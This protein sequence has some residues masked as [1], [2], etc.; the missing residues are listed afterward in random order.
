[1][2]DAPAI[3]SGDSDHVASGNGPAL[4]TD[5]ARQA[6]VSVATVSRALSR[7]EM[8]SAATRDLVQTAVRGTGYRVNQAARN[9]RKQR[10][11][12][13]VA[14]VP[15]LGSPFFAKILAGMGAE[16]A[17]AGYDLLVADTMQDGGRHRALARF[18]DASRADGIIL[19][20]GQVTADDLAALLRAPPVVMACGWINDAA[21][22]RVVLNNGLGI[23]LAARHLLDLDHRRIGWIGGP[24]ENVLHLARCEGLERVLGHLPPG[25]P[26]DFSV[27]SGAGRT[28]LAGRAG[29][30]PPERHRVLQRRNGCGFCR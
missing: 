30:H 21:L 4:L 18:L 14:L 15:N 11:G 10:A 9:L 1:M 6:G 29:M 27:A 2:D 16:L 25:N 19:L 26:G 20:D 23:E 22:A 24:A 8:V 5:V 17:C 13:V 3:A 28:Q 7:P 12:A